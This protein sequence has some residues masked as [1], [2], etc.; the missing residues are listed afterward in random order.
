MSDEVKQTI[1]AA[2]SALTEELYP[3]LAINGSP[4]YQPLISWELEAWRELEMLDF[5]RIANALI[6][7]GI[8]VENI[9]QVHNATLL[10]AIF[11]RAVIGQYPE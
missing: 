1:E 5:T 9:G 3:G 8:Q 4:P 6:Q 7:Q 10:V 2:L 11:K